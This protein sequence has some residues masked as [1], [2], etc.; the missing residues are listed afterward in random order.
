M[1]VHGEADKT[2][3]QLSTSSS[4]DKQINLLGS[5]H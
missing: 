3:H 4:Q 5:M 2:F 1:P